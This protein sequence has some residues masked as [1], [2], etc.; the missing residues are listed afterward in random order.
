MNLIGY[1]VYVLRNHGSPGET[2]RET[3]WVASYTDRNGNIT[4]DLDLLIEHIIERKSFHNGK[5]ISITPLFGGVPI[6]GEK[7]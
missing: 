2:S 4:G 3:I 6:F 1:M 5:L 7:N